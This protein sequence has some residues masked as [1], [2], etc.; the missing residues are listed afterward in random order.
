MTTPLSALL[1]SDG[2]PGHFNLAEGILAAARRLRPVAI[3]RLEVRRGHWPG[4]ILAAWSN[5]GKAPG[6][7]LRLAHR[8][9][10]ATL[11]KADLVVSAG[12]ETL[13]ANVACT[14]I[15]GAA[16]IFYGSLRRFDPA[17]FSL[18]LTSYASD[19]RHPHQAFAL[20]PSPA[21]LLAWQRRAAPATRSA[22]TIGLLIGGSS[23]ETT[24]SDVD[25]QQL[26]NLIT[27]AGA[28]GFRW[29]VAN[30]RRTPTAIG[31]RLAALA[32]DRQSPIERF[33]DARLPDA[34]S[35]MPILAHTALCFVSDD[36]S[37]MVSEA[38]AA[39]LP[40]VGLCPA[41]HRLNERERGYRQTLQ[42]SG[43]YAARSLTIPAEE[44]ID[45][46]LRLTPRTE[47]PASDIARLLTTRLPR[48]FLG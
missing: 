30:S 18:A 5:S 3:V 33:I 9:E 35:L 24:Y 48:L 42:D 1:L 34:P 11:P 38:V 29:Q 37:S 44:L 21:A 13:A 41:D 39:G 22:K 12:A 8:L 7:L 16:N 10:R 6:S 4:S 47:D 27:A 28:R 20:K 45:T 25:W 43:W 19:C 26:F 14:R 32:A 36:S 23:G 31:D 46:A 2:R 40:V 15:L 17:A